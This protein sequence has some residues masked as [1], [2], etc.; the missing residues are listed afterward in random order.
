MT[1]GNLSPE[2]SKR[3]QP[4]FTNFQMVFDLTREPKPNLGLPPN[5]IPGL[6]VIKE[7][8]RGL[9][10]RTV[11]QLVGLKVELTSI[12]KAPDELCSLIRQHGIDV[13]G[14]IQ[15]LS[16]G[17]FLKYGLLDY[18]F[19]V[20]STDLVAER[21]RVR[22][23]K[24]MGL[25]SDKKDV[26]DSVFPDAGIGFLEEMLDE[27]RKN[28]LVVKILLDSQGAYR[29]AQ[30]ALQEQWMNADPDQYFPCEFVVRDA[31]LTNCSLIWLNKH[32]Y[33]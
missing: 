17:A 8:V 19:V 26:D 21:Q 5:A 6:S 31:C 22:F 32:F 2:T 3:K 20:V 7:L 23:L 29:G 24:D 15:D 1:A 25:L 9:R 33:L 10:Y 30:G 18:D 13:A 27:I 12:E 14:D 16:A 4:S 11:D 28:K